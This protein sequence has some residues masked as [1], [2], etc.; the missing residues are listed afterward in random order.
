MRRARVEPA[1][2]GRAAVELASA[3]LLLELALW[4]GEGPAGDG[5]R[6][7]AVLGLAAVALASRARRAGSRPS[8]A[9]ALPVFGAALALTL[10]GSLLVWLAS[11]ASPAAPEPSLAFAF[12]DGAPDV[13]WW[14]RKLGVVLAQQLALQRFVLPLCLEVTRRPGPAFLL[15]GALFGAVHFPNWPLALL[16]GVAAPAWCALYRRGGRLTPIWLSHLVLAVVARATFGDAIHNMR[17]GAAVL[18]LLPR[19]VAAAPD[20]RLRIWPRSVQGFVDGCELVEDAAVCHGWSVDG[21]RGVVSDEIV[22]LAEGRLHRFALSGVPRP[23]VAAHFGR[24]HVER[25]GYRLELPG[26]WFAP[27]R[28]VRFFARAGPRAAELEYGAAYRWAPEP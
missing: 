6:A 17:V 5:G 13:R 7:L 10:L 2:P 22:V 19:T 9:P 27:G 1:R 21:D 23:D 26:A 3:F 24:A 20:D 18:P 28:V 25:C 16:C 12:V 15:A 11:R 8:A 4:L 14:A